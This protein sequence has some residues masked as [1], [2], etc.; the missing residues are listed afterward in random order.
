MVHNSSGREADQSRFGDV[1]SEE[2]PKLNEVQCGF[3]AESGS[4][5]ESEWELESLFNSAILRPA[6]QDLYF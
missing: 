3:C 4:K 2:S 6:R 5:P 1:D